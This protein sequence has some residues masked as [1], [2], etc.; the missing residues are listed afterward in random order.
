MKH[1][2][3][4]PSRLREAFVPSPSL[5]SDAGNE[6]IFMTSP[7]P[8]TDLFDDMP[9]AEDL[10]LDDDILAEVERLRNTDEWKA[11]AAKEWPDAIVT[12]ESEEEGLS[13]D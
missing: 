11:E 9:D 12:Y 13:P 8:A 2:P 4:K 10:G 7:V 6:S 1:T 3:A 5:I